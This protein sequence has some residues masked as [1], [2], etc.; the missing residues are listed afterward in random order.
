[1]THPKPATMKALRLETYGKPFDVLRL[2]DVAI[3]NPGTGQVRV[4]VH[5][6]A[7]NPADWVV[8]EGF[9]PVPPP[10]GIGFDVSG[11]VDALGEGV[12]NVNLGDP[13]FGVP[14]YIGQSTGG[15]A[16]YAILKVFLPIPE[17]LE[18][19]EAA[20]LPMAV[21]TA[22][23]CIDLLPLTAGQT[24]MVNGGGTMT[25][26]A[27]V[28]IALL[29]GAHVIASA[30]ETFADRLRA[31]G[32]KVTP[33]GEGMVERVRELA[34]G[35]PDFAL[36]TAQVKGTLP[37]LVK[38]VDGDPKRVFSFADRDEEGIGVRTAW[39]ENAGIRYDVLGHY[40][41]LAAE[42]LFSIPIARTFA[43]EDWREAAEIS[44]SKKA[45][46][47]LVLLP[48]ASSAGNV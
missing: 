33:Y 18:I 15:A 8:C 25:G 27:A 37:D 12:T 20:A 1:M 35:A 5:A 29:R 21:E 43:L 39:K 26:F 2:E 42:R 32:A 24:L 13:V 16:E 7:L 44:M 36:H 48:G 22:A 46:G 31:L 38:I 30:G 19:T 41:Q 10:I 4:R 9:L 23:R 3:P 40:A 34:G 47:K 45:H 14:D 28:Q 11:I 17:G 6:C